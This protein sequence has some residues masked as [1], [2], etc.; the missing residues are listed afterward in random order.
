MISHCFGREVKFEMEKSFGKYSEEHRKIQDMN[1]N[2]FG[3]KSSK[4]GNEK[5][6]TKKVHES[7][8]MEQNQPQINMLSPSGKEFGAV[9]VKSFRG[10]DVIP[11]SVW[12]R[13]F[14]DYLENLELSKKGTTQMTDKE[15]I[16]HLKIHLDGIPRDVLEQVDPSVKDD[17]GEVKKHLLKSM[18]SPKSLDFARQ[19]LRNTVHAPQESVD[20]FATRLAPLVRAA[21]AGEAESAIMRRT[22]E[23]F[24]DKIREPI[25]LL[26]SG[27]IYSSFEEARLIAK[28][29]EAALIKRSAG[30]LN[31]I[32]SLPIHSLSLNDPSD[33][34]SSRDFYEVHGESS[35]MRRNDHRDFYERPGNEF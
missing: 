18:E 22:L 20:Q 23:E 3:W 14:E 4:F 27:Q 10:N 15:K 24:V 9:K 35:R 11:L 5:N 30:P 28:S 13:K 19:I 26:M 33:F 29:V 2:S 17:Y 6:A 21:Y 7:V 12:F 31:G 1:S 25:G 32:E 8:K 34:P 16:S